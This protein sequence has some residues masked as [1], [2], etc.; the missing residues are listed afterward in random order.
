MPHVRLHRARLCRT[1][2][3]IGPGRLLR[4]PRNPAEPPSRRTARNELAA[5]SS[6]SG[7]GAKADR[8]SSIW[9]RLESATAVASMNAC[10]P[11]LQFESNPG[12]WRKTG[13]ALVSPWCEPR[14]SAET[15]SV[16]NLMKTITYVGS[17]GCSKGAVGD[18]VV[19]ESSRIQQVQQPAAVT[20]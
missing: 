4:Q 14:W 1:V 8:R 16:S 19:S 6:S 20:C 3:P 15:T 9:I 5:C 18:F 13:L 11:E 7:R 2:A 12:D 10:A 17:P